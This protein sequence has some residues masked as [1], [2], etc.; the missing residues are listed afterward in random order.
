MHRRLLSQRPPPA[1]R[2]GP[3]R[4]PASVAIVRRRA[5]A[6]VRT[7]TSSTLTS[8]TPAPKYKLLPVDL[9][10]PVL[11][12]QL[13]NRQ[14]AKLE[15][16]NGIK[17]VV[18][19]DKESPVT[20]AS[21]SVEAG[22]WMD[23]IHDGTAHFTEHMLFLGTKTYPNEYDYERFIYDHNGALN[24]Y[25]ASDHSLYYFQ[26]VTPDAFD[27]A[28]DRFSRFFY[29][30]L[31]NESCVDR[32]MNAVDQEFKKNI[33]Q[34]G[35]RVLHV[36]KELADPK[37]PFAGFNTGNLET[38]KLIDQDY[39][40]GWFRKNYSANLMNF[41]LLGKDS[42]PVLAEKAAAAFSPIPNSDV[43]ILSTTNGR[44]FP[45]SLHGTLTWVEPIKNLRELTLSWEI[46]F[47]YHDMSTK[48]ANLA[49]KVLGYEGTNSLLSLLR[50]H[51]LAEGLSAGKSHLGA[52]NL[53]FEVSISLTE[54]GVREWRGVVSRVFQAINALAEQPYPE[55]L[56][57]EENYMRKIGYQYQQRNSSIATHFCGLLRKEGL[58]T[59]P[60]R[61]YFIDRFDP[62]AARALFT[63]LVPNKC[64]YTI[65]APPNAEVKLD[66]TEKWMGAKYANRPIAD[67]VAR[68]T[69]LG[70]GT[71]VKYPKPNPYV[72]QN[73]KIVPRRDGPPVMLSTN[74]VGG[75]VSSTKS[76]PLRPQI[77]AYSLSAHP[78]PASTKRLNVGI[79]G[80]G[81]AGFYTA[82][83]LLKNLPNVHVDM[84]D[85]LPIPY[86]LIR[87]GVAPDHWE[88]KNVIHKFDLL[89][90]D[91][92]FTFIGNVTIGRDLD[93]TE[94]KPRYD[95]L[96]FSYGASE[97]QKLSLPN[98]DTIPNVFSARAFVG[99]Y[100]GTPEYA[101]LKPDLVS[102]DTAVVVG[103]GNVA[104]DVARTL[105]RPVEELA[106]TDITEYALEALRGSRV[107][108]VRL[109]GRRGP[110]QIAF[111]SKELREMIA[112]PDTKLNLDVALLDSHVKASASIMDRQRQRLMDLLRKGATKTF[113]ANNPPTKS[114]TL[115]FLRSP[116]AL[117]TRDDG[118]LE[119]MMV[120][121]NRLE[122][123]LGAP[124]AVGTGEMEVLKAG[125]LV[126]SIGYRS[127]PLPG[128]P[129]D[130]R[131]GRVPNVRGRVVDEDN[132]TPSPPL[133]VAGWVKRGPTGVIAA[134]MYDAVET[135]DTIIDDV[136]SGNIPSL[137]PATSKTSGGFASVKPLLDAR[138]IQTVSFEGWK[139][140]D[141]VEVR[142]GEEVGKPREK[143]VRV[144]DMLRVA[145]DKPLS[146]QLTNPT[147]PAGKLYF[148]PDSEFL[149]PE[150]LHAFTLKT[151]KI[152]P[153]NPRSIVLAHLYTR[154]VN[155]RLTEL[156]Y[157]AASAGLH[158]DV[159]VAP[160]DTGIAV[161]VEGYSEKAQLLLES[162]LGCVRE[163][164]FTEAEFGI[165]RES[166]SRG[167]RDAGR[168]GP[169]RQAMECM[170][171][172]VYEEY[173]TSA[174]V[175]LCGWWGIPFF[176]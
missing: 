137:T 76:H 12:K 112:L 43:P 89:S 26:S 151:P 173:C 109:V 105:L 145:G 176:C 49:S 101:D 130:E 115:D 172:V 65:I 71:E 119:A 104:L 31:F 8:P 32:E 134:T 138:G 42:I 21:L 33:E 72:P 45:D 116:V 4:Y 29:E 51:E 79:I 86:G 2:L 90:Q 111:T 52:D 135:A 54:K 124:K 174:Q 82:Q 39:L 60:R 80:A 83:H 155:E 70:P 53:L 107:R 28:L 127:A 166:A 14:I 57:E 123:D 170:S 9:N 13:E 148:Y 133:Y 161:S 152:R 96:L 15:L 34:D 142:R 7:F 11:T 38:M 150:C 113:P 147:D 44:V 118:Q 140:I 64:M 125:L 25:T 68:W 16:P 146:P 6:S 153:N 167:Y 92:R 67:E 85:S 154:F 46:P 164:G 87:Y 58:E 141:D 103:Q 61:S 122:G 126:R 23:G 18:I 139:R 74:G 81:P 56:F 78:P 63:E 163:P 41:A 77:R 91:P 5:A 48:P 73:L 22:S 95:A 121:R 128:L 75:R 120:E 169:V 99:W 157:D 66:R 106:K 10:I 110:L 55:H 97:D 50:A 102:S 84:Y 160:G 98:E 36:R 156:S 149:V 35:W 114:W 19:S 40:K 144:E 108:H 30:P 132:T 100:N 136:R 159:A 129:F 171:A 62:D 158:Y 93:L 59:F 47:K 1:S 3:W 94:L 143:V 88:V 27:G 162:V 69:G 117:E 24:G 20:G 168:D 37:H 175:R 165:F 17:G 131:R